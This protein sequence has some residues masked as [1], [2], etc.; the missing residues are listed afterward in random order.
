MEQKF[1]KISRYYD[2]LNLLIS[3]SSEEHEQLRKSLRVHPLKNSKS[4]EAK[5]LFGNYFPNTLLQNVAEIRGRIGFRGLTKKDYR[6]SG[7]VLLSVGNIS[8]NGN[9]VLKQITHI[10][11]DAFQKSPEIIASSTF[12]LPFISNS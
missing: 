10:S 6:D 3:E 5:I 1:L 2:E 12:K 7:P 11:K 8:K 4:L 9:L